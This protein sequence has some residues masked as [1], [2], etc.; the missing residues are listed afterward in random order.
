M[1]PN[2]GGD[3]KNQSPADPSRCVEHTFM[4][5]NETASVK[6]HKPGR[7]GDIRSHVRRHIVKQSKQN[8]KRFQRDEG[9][10]ARY[11]AIAPLG[12]ID[13]P[14]IGTETL[15]RGRRSNLITSDIGDEL[16]K[17]REVQFSDDSVPLEDTTYD[18]QQFNISRGASSVESSVYWTPIS[19]QDS[20]QGTFQAYCLVC[21][22][23]HRFTQNR[24]RSKDDGE[25]LDGQLVRK[26]FF[27]PS[28]LALLGAGRV[29]PFL[30]YPVEKPKRYLHELIDHGK[31]NHS[32][33]HLL[34][35]LSSFMMSRVFPI[36]ACTEL[37]HNS[38]HLPTT[39]FVTRWPNKRNNAYVGDVACICPPIPISLSCISFCR[40]Y[41][42][43]FPPLW[44][45]LSK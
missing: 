40:I 35:M 33:S 37:I 26:D 24:T 4:F 8:Q 43:R 10:G 7:R 3:P 27:K 29:D 23:A 25:V 34:D 38:D 42:S 17:H 5:V 16:G 14:S 31:R 32:V 20:M 15:Q 30:C 28:P 45:H 11:I 36:S 18:P 6:S 9:E 39:R 12:V 1:D 13:G 21:G 41:T 22:T 19:A 2:K 44:P